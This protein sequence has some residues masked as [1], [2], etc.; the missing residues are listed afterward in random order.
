MT[1]P[2]QTAAVQMPPL[3]VQSYDALGFG[4]TDFALQRYAQAYA[5]QQTAL[6]EAKLAK[7]NDTL[8][9]VERWAN[10]HGTKA[11]MTAEQALG[12]IQHYPSIV[13]ITRSY[14]N[15]KVPETRNPWAEL[16]AAEMKIVDLQVAALALVAKVADLIAPNKVLI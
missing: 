10:H 13:E 4:H 1:L 11:H 6:I 9:F 2:T 14:S 7:A 12:C 3:P 5:A 16:A 8:Q 15:G